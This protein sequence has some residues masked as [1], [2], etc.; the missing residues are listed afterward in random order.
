MAQ[1][2]ALG[3][4]SGLLLLRLPV[5]HVY[6]AFFLC[7]L[8]LLAGL[9]TTFLT[10]DI[11][12]PALPHRNVIV[13]AWCYVG[14]MLL[15]LGWDVFERFR[16]QDTSEQRLYKKVITWELVSLVILFAWLGFQ[17]FFANE[18]YQGAVLAAVLLLITIWF[19]V[20]AMEKRVFYRLAAT[21]PNLAGST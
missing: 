9:L 1:V 7:H 17:Q 16:T 13:V 20:L 6:P 19:A 10:I 11:N 15:Y 14:F 5:H 8:I 4:N 18:S 12:T 21:S 2:D 3:N